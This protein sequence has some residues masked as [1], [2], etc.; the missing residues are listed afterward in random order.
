MPFNRK[1]LQATDVQVD[2]ATGAILV[3]A[4]PST[5]QSQ[6]DLLEFPIYHTE[7]VEDVVWDVQYALADISDPQFA[8]PILAGDTSVKFEDLYARVDFRD[9]P[10]TITPLTAGGMATKMSE[11]GSAFRSGSLLVSLNAQFLAAMIPGHKYICRARQKARGHDEWS[12]H[13][14]DI[15]V[16]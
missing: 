16:W 8:K 4:V 15:I 13:H 6:F 2:Q 10:G 9:V 12:V 7:G 5:A 3:L 1:W 11:I 14:D